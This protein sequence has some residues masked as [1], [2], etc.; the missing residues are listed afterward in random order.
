VVVEPGA[1][2]ASTWEKALADSQQRR[3]SLTPEGDR[4][5]GKGFDAVLRRFRL[6][7]PKAVPA[8]EAAKVIRRAIEDKSPKTRYSIGLDSRLLMKLVTILPDKVIDYLMAELVF[9]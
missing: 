5:Y 1:V 2:R 3:A 6:T 4:L 9:K 7:E 8:V